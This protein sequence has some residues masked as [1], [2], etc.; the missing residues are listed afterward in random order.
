MNQIN[1][2]VPGHVDEKVRSRCPKNSTFLNFNC[3]RPNPHR[4]LRTNNDIRHC[5]NLV[6]F[7]P[8]LWPSPAARLALCVTKG[9][10]L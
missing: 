9:Q 2:R 6:R 10:R 8:R 7:L 1:A 5:A 3:G 4:G